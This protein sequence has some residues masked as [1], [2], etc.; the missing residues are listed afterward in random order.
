MPQR[1][2]ATRHTHRFETQDLKPAA[3]GTGDRY[4]SPVTVGLRSAARRIQRLDLGVWVHCGQRV[5]T[6]QGRATPTQRA[7]LETFALTV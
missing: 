2:L 7:R 1:Q 4:P 6:I 5:V 3:L